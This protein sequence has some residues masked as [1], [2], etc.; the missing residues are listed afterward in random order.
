[1][2]IRFL[3]NT[4]TH[5]LN[6]SNFIQKTLKSSEKYLKMNMEQYFK[7]SFTFEFI[8]VILFLPFK[9]E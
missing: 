7:S 1:M 8:F 2:R 4:S 5:E 3:V 9:K 6:V